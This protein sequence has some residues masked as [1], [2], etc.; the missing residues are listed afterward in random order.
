MRMGKGMSSL[1]WH[2]F[3]H[4]F[5]LMLGFTSKQTLR[6]IYESSLILYN[7]QNPLSGSAEGGEPPAGVSG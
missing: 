3:S 6:A 7:L 5:R 2:P 1:G 4:M